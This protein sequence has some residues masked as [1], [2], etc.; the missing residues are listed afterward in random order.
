MPEDTVFWSIGGVSILYII[1]M[2]GIAR[3]L[4]AAH[5]SVWISIGSPSFLNSSISNGQKL[6]RYVLFSG[7]HHDLHDTR[8]THAIWG[9]RLL[10]LINIGL[11][12]FWNVLDRSHAH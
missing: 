6:N 7:A 3:Y 8:L 9:L 10:I 11:M 1:G 2:F 12:V 4:R 5:Q